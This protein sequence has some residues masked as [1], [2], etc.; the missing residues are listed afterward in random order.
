MYISIERGM[1]HAAV[2]KSSLLAVVW[3]MVFAPLYAAPHANKKKP[4]VAVLRF[5]NET[6]NKG[7]DF[8]GQSLADSV[9]A[10]LSKE[11][12]I[13]LVERN[14]LGAVLKEMELQ[15][16]GLFDGDTVNLPIKKIPADILVVGVYSGQS[17]TL[18]VS[19]KAVDVTTASVIAMRRATGSV[20]TI[21]SQLDALLSEFIALLTG[22][23]LAELTV[24]TVP[25][26][27]A[28]YLDGNFV[29]ESP[30]VALKTTKGRH[31]IQVTKKKYKT[32]EQ[33]ID[34]ATDEKRKIDLFLVETLYTNRPYAS[35]SGFLFS[36]LSGFNKS[37]ALGTVGIGH[38]FGD[39]LIKFEFAAPA[40]SSYTYSYKV[41]YSQ[42]DDTREYQFYMFHI[43]FNYH[44]W[45]G[46]TIAPYAGLQ[47]GYTRILE[48]EI[49]K[50][51]YNVTE[52]E[53]LIHIATGIAI[54][55][56]DIFPASRF[57]FFLKDVITNRST[58]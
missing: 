31:T 3:L 35:I 50:P 20:D 5:Q 53:R 10:R 37:T 19:I 8:L 58:H 39:A 42:L 4:A 6:K 21:F 48:A 1:R 49:N 38:S 45:A 27:A 25:D 28:V 57:V 14:H 2:K 56:V 41:P 26:G 16:S 12:K 23:D 22:E 24:A 13:R 44:F 51:L 40:L 52:D 29:G 11:K 55:G 7:L 46:E 36:P 18:Q 33:A 9:A 54:L 30:V 34:V 43:G 47:V 32:A 17:A 15:Q